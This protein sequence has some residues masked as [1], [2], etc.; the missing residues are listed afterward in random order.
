MKIICAVLTTNIFGVLFTSFYRNFIRCKS[1]I[2]YFRRLM[3]L[4]FY[5]V[6]VLTCCYILS[7][8]TQLV[9][10]Q[11]FKN[12]I[13]Q[14][15]TTV[16]LRL[17]QNVSTKN[18]KA[19]DQVEFT[20]VEKVAADGKT[21]IESGSTAVGRVSVADQPDHLGEPGFIQVAP[22]YVLA[23]DGQKVRLAGTY[24]SSGEDKETST[25]ICAWLCLPLGLRKGG[26]ANIVEGTELRAIVERDYEVRVAD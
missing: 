13:L 6:I 24:G 26:H 14:Q 11:T 4:T 22:Q 23:V 2:I 16:I 3:I 21:V 25:V 5:L 20:V 7:G 19:G 9:Y 12:V 10:A 8:H 18:M 1:S 17:M 15:N